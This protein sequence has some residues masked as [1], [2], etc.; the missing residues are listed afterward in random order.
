MWR[1]MCSGGRGLIPLCGALLVACGG[2]LPAKQPGAVL[3]PT[4]LCAASDP[5]QVVAPQQ[6]VLL[7]STQLM[8]MIRLVSDDAAKLIVDGAVFAVTSDLAARF[9]PAR[10][11]Q[12]KS[13]PDATSLSVFSNTAQKVGEYVRDHFAAV[14]TCP[15]PATDGCATSYLDTLAGKAYRRPLTP[16]EQARFRSLYDDLRTAIV[17]D[18]AITLT[19]EEATGF[20]VQALLLSPQLLWR[21]EIGAETS[22][23]PPGVFLTDAELASN[24]SFFLTDG[25]PDDALR[26]DASAGTLR[27]NLGAHVDRILATP[28]ARQWLTHVMQTYFLLNQL[29]GTII[30]H[31]KFP[32]VAGGALYADLYQESRLFLG[33]VMWNGKVTDLLTS[34]K[35]FL[36][37]NLA[38][39]IYGVPVPAGATATH[40][41]ETM[42]PADERAGM[43]TDAGFLTTRARA[44]G[45]GLVPRGLSVK[46][47]FTCVETPPPLESVVQPGSP[48][49]GNLDV[50]TAQEQVALRAAAPQCGTCHASFDPYGL[51]LDWYDV[52]GRYRTVDD[53][54]KPVDGRTKLPAEVGGA[55]ID[56][57]VELA[58]V[59]SKSDVFTNCLAKSVLDDALVGAWVELPLP[60]HQR[61]GC[62]AAGVADNLRRSE[63]RSFTDLFR[64]AATSP[65]FVLRTVDASV[66]YDDTPADTGSRSAPPVPGDPVLANLSARRTVLDFVAQELDGLRRMRPTEVRAKLDNHHDAVMA[67]Q[68][69]LT[70][71]IDAFNSN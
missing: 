45:V 1:T 28:A 3:P 21:W 14:T 41:A 16:D 58:D 54:G 67:M 65:A 43:L 36:N 13:I 62:A 2:E 34:R 48:A 24:L 38:S 18:Q 22:S 46:A 51:V 70:A 35:A 26:A 17:K 15:S 71:A 56:T 52:V 50:Q 60:S 64:A 68:S 53:F 61:A 42:L 29:P 55:E 32:I 57:A 37:S 40:F 25:P 47:L 10:F 33:D 30:D 12:F 66:A 49:V 8:N 4:P 11:E 9:P 7:T 27:A 63:G 23:S 20:A 69:A 39:M 31:G 5:A 6:I 59:L 19:V 44:T